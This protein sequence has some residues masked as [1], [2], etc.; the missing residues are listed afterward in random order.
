MGIENTSD[1]PQPHQDLGQMIKQQSEL[2]NNQYGRGLQLLLNN[3]PRFVYDSELWQEAFPNAN[4]RNV[5]RALNEFFKDLRG[6]LKSSGLADAVQPYQLRGFH[7]S[8]ALR[9]LN[10]HESFLPVERADLIA[11]MQ[12]PQAKKIALMTYPVYASGGVLQSRFEAK[13]FVIVNFLLQYPEKPIP[14]R[15]LQQ[16]DL[17]DGSTNVKYLKDTIDK[18]FSNLGLSARLTRGDDSL[19]INLD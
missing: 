12:N 15:F 13:N 5:D 17:I 11:S 2:Q 10:Q 19:G 7:S 6:R 1:I 4:V 3:L 8:I 16:H 9:P 18:Q 14:Y